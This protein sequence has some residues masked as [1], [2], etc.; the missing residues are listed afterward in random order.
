[1]AKRIMHRRIAVQCSLPLLLALA[2][3][4]CGLASA[5]DGKP[6]S[7]P[8]E[9]PKGQ[10]NEPKSGGQSGGG[11]VSTGIGVDV[12]EVIGLFRHHAK[13]QLQANPQQVPAGQPVVFTAS[14]KP[15]A[16][17]L[18]YEFHWTKDKDSPGQQETTPS[19]N[20]V[21]PAPGQ[22]AASVI[23][24]SKGKKVAVSND[25]NIVVQQAVA[26]TPAPGPVVRDLNLSLQANEV[27][28]LNIDAKND[29]D[30][31]NRWEVGSEGFPA[32]MHLNGDQ[33]LDVSP[34]SKRNFQLQ[35]D[36]SGLKEGQHEGVFT[37][38]CVTCIPATCK[39]A[40]NV[41]KVHLTVQP[42][43][44][45]GETPPPPGKTPA[46]PDKTSETAKTAIPALPPPAV[47]TPSVAPPAST[48]NTTPTNPKQTGTLSA[49]TSGQPQERNALGAKVPGAGISP[50]PDRNAKSD[51]SLA[52][53]AE[54]ARPAVAAGSA[55]KAADQPSTPSLLTVMLALI[56]ILV[57]L[58]AALATR[59][60]RRV[61]RGAVS[62]HADF[63][64][65]RL[66]PENVEAG[67]G[68]HIRCVRGAVASKIIFTPSGPLP[69]EKKET[70]HV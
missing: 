30:Q 13:V 64:R 36:S 41:F 29:C 10:G 12:G 1:M 24:Y 42:V 70:A 62:V 16:A 54:E 17:G 48:T 11:G 46:P 40:A 57:L 19:A 25:V 15:N 14:V 6:G 55:P 2:I 44:A 65:H 18:T 4:T 59:H 32:F 20:H 21:Y 34:R 31:Q 38:R 45:S 69:L 53:K 23:V 60:A 27:K 61:A 52:I 8:Q 47:I 9:P 51:S 68:L 63:G 39:S 35:Y 33:S 26:T 66:S 67:E 22:Y 37:V 49:E 5:Q 7:P 56:L 3:S 43:V 58:A 50:L 28:Y